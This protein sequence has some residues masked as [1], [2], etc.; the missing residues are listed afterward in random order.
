LKTK[1]GFININVYMYI[2]NY[3]SMYKSICNEY[4]NVD[5]LYDTS[6]DVNRND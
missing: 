4:D 6:N 3:S 2:I 5:S 1:L